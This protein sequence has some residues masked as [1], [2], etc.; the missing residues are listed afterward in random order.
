[1]RKLFRSVKRRVVRRLSPGEQAAVRLFDQERALSRLHRQGVR[2][3]HDHGLSRPAKLN[4]G[5]GPFSKPGFL[6]VDMSPAGDVCLDLR[7]ELPFESAC[8]ELI[9]SEHCLEHFDYPEPISA[10]LRECL[11]VLRPGGELVFSV[12]ETAWPLLD[13][14]DGPDSPYFRACGEHQW[15]PP[16]CTTRMEH[17]N[18]HFR[19]DGEHRYA[20]DLE[21]AEKLLRQVGFVD[22]RER[23]FDPAL[24]SVHRRIGSLFMAARKPA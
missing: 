1:M 11:R 7:R 24:D 8:C 15:H 17:I 4:L 14:G 22:I 21:T 18:Y 20:Y 2:R 10:L 6:N 5:C 23:A 13:Y 19:Q 3:V 9:F 12:P 16:T